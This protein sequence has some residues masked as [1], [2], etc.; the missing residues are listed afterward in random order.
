M[1]DEKWR[2]AKREGGKVLLVDGVEC[3][4]MPKGSKCNDADKTMFLAL[5]CRPR[6]IE[7]EMYDGKIALIPCTEDYVTK[8]KSQ[9]GPKGTLIQINKNVDAAFYTE[10][11]C[12]EGDGLDQIE[13]YGVWPKES[14]VTMQHDGAKAHTGTVQ[15]TIEDSSCTGNGKDDVRVDVVQQPSNSP[16]CNT[17]DIGGFNAHQKEF[18]RLE[19]FANNKQRTMELVYRAWDN[20]SWKV[21]DKS[22]ASFLTTYGLL[23]VAGENSKNFEIRKYK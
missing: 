11:W 18:K 7:G 14:R 13:S 9:F 17:W 19:A 22:W 1:A 10:L 6:M 15:G 5:G 8:R 3:D 2:F 4:V 21:M 16:D 23:C 12:E 20:I